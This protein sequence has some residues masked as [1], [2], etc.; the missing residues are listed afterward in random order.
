MQHRVVVGADFASDVDYAQLIASTHDNPVDEVVGPDDLCMIVHTSGT[1]GLPKGVMLTHGNITWNLVNLLSVADFR[2]DDVTVAVTP[3]F[4]TGGT[5]VNVLPVLFKGGTVVVPEAGDPDEILGLLERWHVTVG[6]GNPDLLELITRSPRWNDADLS[7]IRLFITGGA[8]VPEQLIRTYME[9]GVTFLQGY[10][11]SEAAPLVLLLDSRSA[12]CKIGSAGKP[13][14]FVDVRTIRRDGKPCAPDE[15][16]ELL[17]TGPNVMTG[18]WNRPV[19]TREAIDED[20]WLHTGDAARIDDE[21]FVW[22]VDRVADAFDASGHVVYPGD[23]E[24]VFA[25]HPAVAD[26]CVASDDGETR[27]VR[28]ARLKRRRHRSTTL[29]EFARAELEPYAVPRSITF[30]DQ[31]PRNSVGKLLRHELVL[32]TGSPP[33]AGGS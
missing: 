17:V 22:I 16:G 32:R 1:T 18:Y 20:G 12:T 5:G 10:G 29:L 21:G 9:R 15:T 23:V 33:R 25:R 13:P 26:V 24:R 14:L 8:P 30:V 28:R 11:L 6:F 19:E 7:A 2:G 31:L 27:G 3:F 4:R